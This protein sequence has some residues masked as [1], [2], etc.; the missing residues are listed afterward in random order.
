LEERVSSYS[1]RLLEVQS[2]EELWKVLRAWDTYNK[3][4]RTRKVR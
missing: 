2:D 1:D 4:R 3:D